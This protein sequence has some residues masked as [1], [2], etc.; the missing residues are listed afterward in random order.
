MFLWAII[1]SQFQDISPDMQCLSLAIVIAGA[2]AGGDG[3]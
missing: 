1:M 3:K 2:M